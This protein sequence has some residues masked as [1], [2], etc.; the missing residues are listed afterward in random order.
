MMDEMIE[1]PLTMIGETIE[2]PPTSDETIDPPPTMIGETIEQPPTSDEMIEMPPT[3][4]E[5]MIEQP[6]TMDE[7][8]EMPLAI[9]ETIEQQPTIDETPPLRLRPIPLAIAPVL[10]V[11]PP[12]PAP[13]AP[14]RELVRERDLALD[15]SFSEP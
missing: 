10:A 1:M 8:I 5:E 9:D 12:R 6:P 2:Q 14:L 3:M 7:M 13:K 4:T 11:T 15:R